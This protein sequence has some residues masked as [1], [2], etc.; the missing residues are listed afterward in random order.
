MGELEWTATIVKQMRSVGAIVVP[1]VGNMRQKNGFPDR[2]LISGK[3]RCAVF[4]EFKDEETRIESL[5]QYTIDEINKR[6]PYT[7]FVIRRQNSG[8]HCI[9]YS[10][11]KIAEFTNGASLLDKL[12][13][14]S[15]V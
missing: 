5:Q 10:R 2:I 13:G 6:H 14:K 12:R 15:V 8:K 9:V 3:L 11:I 1:Y 7:A 4:L